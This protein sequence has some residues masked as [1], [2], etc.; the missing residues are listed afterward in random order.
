M[1]AGTPI[2]QKKRKKSI[3]K[4]IRQAERRAEINRSNRT[5]VRTMIKRMR[6]A[7]NAG[8]AAAAGALL[9]PTLSAI[10]RAIQK[11]ILRENTANRYK[12]RLTIAY[13][14]LRSKGAAARA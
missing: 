9:R 5:R 6:A 11:K 2:K 1:P 7:L 3:L 10:D 13:N 14:A 12:S 8:D 4:R